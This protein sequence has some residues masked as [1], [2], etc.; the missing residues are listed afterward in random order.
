MG[1]GG[2][3]FMEHFD[4]LRRVEVMNGSDLPW[5]AKYPG[6]PYRPWSPSVGR[7]DDVHANPERFAAEFLAPAAGLSQHLGRRVSPVKSTIWPTTT[8]SARG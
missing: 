4:C 1:V 2:I 7:G 8:A 3:I 5:N 6:T